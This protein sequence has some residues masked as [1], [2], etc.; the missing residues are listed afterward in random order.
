MPAATALKSLKC[1]HKL[2]LIPRNRQRPLTVLAFCDSWA[3]SLDN[4]QLCGVDMFGD[5]TY[6]TEGITKIAEML[7]M[8]TTLQSIRWVLQVLA[9]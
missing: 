3:C 1:P 2:K 5:G 6:T 8:N 4:N 9:F 7:A